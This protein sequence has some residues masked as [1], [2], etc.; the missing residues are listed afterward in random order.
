MGSMGDMG[1]EE[2]WKKE[3]TVFLPALV[4]KLP[5]GN[6]IVP[7]AP[8]FFDFARKW[9]FQ[10]RLEEKRSFQSTCVPKRE[11]GNE[12]LEDLEGFE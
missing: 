2:H 8:L 7:K 1:T 4:P 10:T 3:A 11:L 5:L 9:P 12:S 6:A